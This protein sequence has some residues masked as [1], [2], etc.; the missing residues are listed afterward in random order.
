[1]FDE[2]GDELGKEARVWKVYVDETDKWDADLVNR[3]DRLVRVLIPRA[4]LTRFLIE[5]SN[6]LRKD[7]ADTSAESL[8]I[9]TRTLLAMANNTRP[10]DLDDPSS[11]ISRTAYQPSRASVLIN[12]LWYLS[13][14]LSVVTSLLAMLAKEWCHSFMAGR[15][16]HPF[17]QARRRQ[18]KWNKIEYW[19]MRQV[20]AAL[21]TLMHLALRK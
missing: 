7:P 13:L 4:W 2:T 3:W 10:P 17:T 16:G 14:S 21:P 6:R 19:R 5:S 15:I 11:A 9:I 8:V 20:L 1:E 12:A 18:Q